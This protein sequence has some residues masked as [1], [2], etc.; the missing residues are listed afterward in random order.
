MKSLYFQKKENEEAVRA[1]L[2]SMQPFFLDDLKEMEKSCETKHNMRIMAH[3]WG[4]A[5]GV[6]YD[7]SIKENK[8]ISEL[9]KIG[10]EKIGI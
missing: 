9:L 7:E 2:K 5:L 4:Y 3:L 8:E 6:F 10:N 1:I